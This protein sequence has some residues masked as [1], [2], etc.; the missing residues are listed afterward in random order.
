MKKNTSIIGHL[1]ALTFGILLMFGCTVAHAQ[2]NAVPDLTPYAGADT[3]GAVVAPFIQGFAGT[4]PWLLTLLTIMAT[5][6]VVAKPMFSAIEAGMGPDSAAAK[7]LAAAEAGPI[8]KGIA[9]L[10]DFLFSIKAH[11]LTKT[12]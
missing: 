2:T 4:H 8:Y 5:V 3:T 9:W 11:L 6:R 7:K 1:I 12:P 10:L